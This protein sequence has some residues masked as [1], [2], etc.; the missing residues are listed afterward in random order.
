MNGNTEYLRLSKDP[1]T[2]VAQDV[3]PT[4]TKIYVD[5]V[6]KL[7]FMTPTAENP[8]VVF[9]GGER[10]TYYEVSL[11]DNYITQVKKSHWRYCK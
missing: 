9:I 5:D 6:T 8:G 10:I 2:T 11:E 4:D 1:T 7:P 3:F